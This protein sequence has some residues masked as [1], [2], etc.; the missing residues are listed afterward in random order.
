MNT[1]KQ[2]LRQELRDVENAQANLA[3]KAV[4]TWTLHE[5]ANYQAQLDVLERRQRVLQHLLNCP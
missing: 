4:R 5:R 3:L 2:L 1:R